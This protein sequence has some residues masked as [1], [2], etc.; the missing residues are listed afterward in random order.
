MEQ[1]INYIERIEKLLKNK[2][3]NVKKMLEDLGYAHGLISNWKKGSE[4]SAIKLMKIAEYLNTDLNYIMYGRIKKET[5]I[6]E[7]WE[8]LDYDEKKIIEQQ[9]DTLIAVKERKAG[10]LSS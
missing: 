5:E 7:K 4:P 8:K 10:K 2:N 9:I 1:K 6:N 3:T